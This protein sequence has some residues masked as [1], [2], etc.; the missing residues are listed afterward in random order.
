MVSVP[1]WSRGYTNKSKEKNIM[2]YKSRKEKLD[3]LRAL[4]ENELTN[5]LFE[6][7]C[8]QFEDVK[9]THGPQEYGADIIFCKFDDYL[10]EKRYYG[11][12]VKTG[13]I[14]PKKAHDILNQLM[15]AYYHEYT[16]ANTSFNLDYIWAATSGKFT[17][18]AEKVI[19]EYLRSNRLSKTIKIFDGNKICELIEKNIPEVFDTG[20]ERVK[21]ER[22]KFIKSNARYR[23]DK[24][25]HFC[26]DKLIHL[27]FSSYV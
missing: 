17:E 27:W 9:I 11:V 18:T 4:S 26:S 25:T 1:A 8:K 23:S 12:Q 7:F 24:L 3:Y 16:T 14:T 22:K 6:L 19:Y 15:R 21:D 5:I 2:M 10:K 20:H 13:D